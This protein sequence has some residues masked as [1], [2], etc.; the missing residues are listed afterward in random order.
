MDYAVHDTYF[1]VSHI[2][3]VLFGGSLFGIF[4][5]VYYWFPKMT[6]RI[7]DRRLGNLQFWLLFIWFNV[8]FFPMHYLGLC[9]HAA[10]DR[11]VLRIC[12]VEHV[13]HGRDDRLVRDRARH[14]RRAREPHRH[15]AQAAHRDRRPLGRE[16]AG[17]GDDEAA[18]AAQLRRAARD[19]V[20]TSGPRPAAGRN[21]GE[22]TA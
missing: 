12:R 2:H 19:H 20:R 3:Y 7:L 16:H 4:A 22:V 15:V 5:G 10:A 11:D 18:A 13:E 14:D 9:G 6:G 21:R 17:V 1:V 8:T